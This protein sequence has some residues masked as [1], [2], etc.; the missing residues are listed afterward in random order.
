MTE[1]FWE[2]KGVPKTLIFAKINTREK[3]KIL[4]EE[5]ISKLIGNINKY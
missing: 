2:R 1:M 3:G 4:Y 5:Y